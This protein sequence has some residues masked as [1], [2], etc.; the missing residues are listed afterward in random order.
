MKIE[1]T[2][3]L[4]LNGK[5]IIKSCTL[6]ILA[7]LFFFAVQMSVALLGGVFFSGGMEEF[8]YICNSDWRFD[9]FQVFLMGICAILFGLFSRKRLPA[10]NIQHRSVRFLMIVLFI[11][12]TGLFYYLYCRSNVIISYMES[13]VLWG[14]EAGR[15]VE[16]L[17]HIVLDGLLSFRN[18]VYLF[19]YLV[20]LFFPK[21]SLNVAGNATDVKQ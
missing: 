16:L 17:V 4:I 13:L 18:T 9:I 11:L 8:V 15:M 6:L 21:L 20:V 12:S 7:Y 5:V 10:D 1:Y 2:L 14:M 3:N 19:V